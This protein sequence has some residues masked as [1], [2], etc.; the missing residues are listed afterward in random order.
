MCIKYVCLACLFLGVVARR[1]EE[2]GNASRMKASHASSE[3]QDLDPG[4]HLQA[5]T[6]T[7]PLSTSIL[8]SPPCLPALFPSCPAC[9]PPLPPPQQTTIITIPPHSF[10]QIYILS[11]LH[12]PLLKHTYTQTQQPTYT[13]THT[14][15]TRMGA[16]LSSPITDKESEDGEC[17][18]L[19]Y[20]VS[21]MQGLRRSMEDAHLAGVCVCMCVCVYV[22]YGAIDKRGALALAFLLFP[23]KSLPLCVIHINSKHT[24]THNNNNSPHPGRG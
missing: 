21:A 13:H 4:H 15:T 1:R 2:D 12:S 14:T 7:R 3:C 9:P 6:H 24:H 11:H 22:P 17:A 20:G 10:N 23:F 8:P 16:Y 19:R 18:R 5:H